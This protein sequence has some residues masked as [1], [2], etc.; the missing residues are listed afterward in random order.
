MEWCAAS[1]RASRY[2]GLIRFPFIHTQ[3]N[4]LVRGS[5]RQHWPR[6]DILTQQRLHAATAT[7]WHGEG[8]HHL[9][10]HTSDESA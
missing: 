5:R 9:Q 4:A 7:K 1:D 8:R 2:A 3:R 6:C 10:E